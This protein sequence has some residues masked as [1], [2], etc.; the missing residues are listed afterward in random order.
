MNKLKVSGVHINFTCLN[1][2]IRG[3]IKDQERIILIFLNLEKNK[4]P[5]QLDMFVDS[6]KEA[7]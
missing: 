3:L 2:L 7:I 6:S 4:F 5:I 1:L